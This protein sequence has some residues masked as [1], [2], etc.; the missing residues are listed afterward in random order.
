MKGFFHVRTSQYGN[1]YMQTFEH[2]IP[3]DE[4]FT[5]F[6]TK[7]PLNFA[8][9]LNRSIPQIRRIPPYFIVFLT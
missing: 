9:V 4:T 1:P 2:F 3:T 8:N 7:M 6:E 5:R